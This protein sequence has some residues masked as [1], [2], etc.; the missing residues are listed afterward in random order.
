MHMS[1]HFIS[2]AVRPS[3]LTFFSFF[4][5]SSPSFFSLSSLFSLYVAPPGCP[6]GSSY[7]FRYNEDDLNRLRGWLFSPKA[8]QGGLEEELVSL[9]EH[10][11]TLSSR[12]DDGVV[13]K[14][15][16]EL[17]SNK[18]TYQE[19]CRKYEVFRINLHRKQL[20]VQR[21]EQRIDDQ[22]GPGQGSKKPSPAAQTPAAARAANNNNTT[23]DNTRAIFDFGKA[24][25]IAA[26]KVIQVA[27]EA[28]TKK[29]AAEKEKAA[30]EEKKTEEEMPTQQETD[31]IA[32]RDLRQQRE[33]E[34]VRWCAVCCM[35]C[36]V[37]LCGRVAM[38]MDSTMH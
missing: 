22:D 23:V 30:A 32:T 28:K 27:E 17:A 11:N 20:D 7:D 29:A 21:L 9:K 36:S 6:R 25:K 5:L 8:T 2:A 26:A 38:A 19:F 1:K 37:L 12:S 16:A 4:A 13:G 31:A 35:C 14:L 34:K 18:I 10:V 24:R 3:F 33:I 15:K